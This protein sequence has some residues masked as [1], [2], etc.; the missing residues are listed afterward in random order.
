[1]VSW[2]PLECKDTRVNGINRRDRSISSAQWPCGRR[3]K[4]VEDEMRPHEIESWVLDVAE[5]VKKR[6][7]VEDV[8][9][10]LKSEWIDAK[11]AARRMAGHA[12][13]AHGAP[14][15]WIIGLDETNGVVGANHEEMASW[16]QSVASCFS[17][18]APVMTDLN[19]PLD[20]E[21]LVAILLETDRAPYL[22][23]VPEGRK[24]EV[25]IPY[26]A[27]TGTRSAR[28]GEVLRILTPLQ[29]VPKLDLFV[30]NLWLE[31]QAKSAKFRLTVGVELYARTVD[32]GRVAIPFHDC[33]AV[34]KVAGNEVGRF[35][36]LGIDKRRT[37]PYVIATETEVVLE[38]PGWL[39]VR[40]NA[41]LEKPT[42]DFAADAEV[43][44]S[45]GILEA[46]SPTT[47]LV[48]LSS[49]KAEPGSAFWTT[50]RLST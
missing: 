32:S 8:R 16:W 31:R 21:T 4:G 29:K 33:Y 24:V 1:M 50:G 19:V 10:E 14:I 49:K 41:F 45:L 42:F 13:A 39:N 44:L 27:A 7:P 20:G 30:C 11:K 17:E 38:G 5:R 48:S 36:A 34:V 22:V 26:R 6:Q 37:T 43:F 2:N 47:F 15:L 46:P 3:K 12:N 23:K 28:R 40:G 9:V 25:E 18:V 35:D